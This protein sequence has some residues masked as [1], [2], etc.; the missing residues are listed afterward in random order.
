MKTKDVVAY[1]TR[2]VV[3][4]LRKKL[5]N[6]DAL[7]IDDLKAICKYDF[8]VP[9]R[10]INGPLDFYGQVDGEY[11]GFKTRIIINSAHSIRT[12][13]RVII[14]E[15]AEIIVRRDMP[16]TWDRAFNVY[17]YVANDLLH[18]VSRMTERRMY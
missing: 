18:E 15:L 3:E 6:I 8:G 9:V 10:S 12:Q 2:R 13:R 14:H 5:G 7:T 17:F 11:D 4:I 16:A 1:G